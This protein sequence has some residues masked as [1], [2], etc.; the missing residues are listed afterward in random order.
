MLKHFHL[1]FAVVLVISF[2]GRVWLAEFKP[3]LL[4]R[5][6]IKIVPHVVAGAVLLSGLALVLQG[7][8]LGGAYGWIVAKLLVLVAF[9]GLGIVAIHQPGKTRWFAFLGALLCLYYIV[10]VAVTKQVFFFF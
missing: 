10:K 6:A 2:V 7:N 5:K 9:I 8:L 3:E 1:L 4:R